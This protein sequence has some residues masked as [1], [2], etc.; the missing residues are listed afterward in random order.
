MMT[1]N[2]YYCSYNYHLS[3]EWVAIG[4]MGLEILLLS[5]HNDKDG[6][7]LESAQP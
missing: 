7:G 3:S 6:T 1:T 4:K 5:S 2:G